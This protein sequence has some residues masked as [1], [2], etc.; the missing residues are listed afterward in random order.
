MQWREAARA[1]A[2]DVVDSSEGTDDES[3]AVAAASGPAE[4]A[5]TESAAE[6]ATRQ[7]LVPAPQKKG[8]FKKIGGWFSS[9]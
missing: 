6:T 5:T 7:V 1:A 2:E 3:G 9:S 4:T 8:L